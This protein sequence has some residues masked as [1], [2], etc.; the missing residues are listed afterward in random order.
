[1][2]GPTTSVAYLTDDERQAID[3]YRDARKTWPDTDQVAMLVQIL[4]VS[5]MLIDTPEQRAAIERATRLGASRAMVA[6]VAAQ[7]V[8]GPGRGAP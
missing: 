5:R 8:Q 1:M 7:A 2:S 6:H 4:P 3:A